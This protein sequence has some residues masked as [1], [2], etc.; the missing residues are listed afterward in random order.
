M[1][2]HA[3]TAHAGYRCSGRD[4]QAGS[5]AGA[6]LPACSSLPTLRK[7]GE[8]LR[9]LV[10][11]SSAVPLLHWP[12]SGFARPLR[13]VRSTRSASAP[14]HRWEGPVPNVRPQTCP[15]VRPVSSD[16]PCAPSEPGGVSVH[17][18]LFVAYEELDVRNLRGG[19][20]ST[21]RQRVRSAL[22]RGLPKD[23]AGLA[24]PPWYS[25]NA[26]RGK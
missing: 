5:A 21:G 12:R 15:G 10:L 16:P 11:R 4:R 9:F 6:S 26:S 22:V 19:A 18:L 23:S 2:R 13:Q 20:T 7:P 25:P 3:R 24:I 1:H 8:R 14:A 17:E